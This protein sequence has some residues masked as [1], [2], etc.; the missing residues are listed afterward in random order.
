M[1][2]QIQIDK[3]ILDAR[4]RLTMTSVESVDGFSEQ[5]LKL[6]A[7]GCK[8]LILGENIKITAYNKESGNL[9]ADGIFNSIKF[10]VKKESILKRIFK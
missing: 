9:S 2:D 8:V 1:Q 3:L 6:K 7:G 10:D 4:K 5:F